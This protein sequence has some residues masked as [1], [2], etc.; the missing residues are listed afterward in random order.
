MVIDGISIGCP[1]CSFHDCQRSLAKV[2][3][4][5]CSEHAHLVDQCC[6]T[7]CINK[8]RRNRQ[9]C[10]LSSHARLEDYRNEQGKAMFQL[11]Q[12]LAR[13]KASNHPGQSVL[14]NEALAL[15][16]EQLEGNGVEDGEEDVV[17]M[18]DTVGSLRIE[19]ATTTSCV[20]KAD[21]GNSKL[22]ARFGRRRMNNEELCV[23][24]CGV[25]LGRC[26]MFGSEAPNGVRVC[27]VAINFL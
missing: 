21:D 9:T 2:K 19:R 1:V 18:E 13:L 25:I 23:A 3:D 12:R 15:H 4:R 17:V 7:T 26:S 16:T 11:R 5:Y 8:V 27:I 22:T 10:A 20:G 14:V 24:S 6:V